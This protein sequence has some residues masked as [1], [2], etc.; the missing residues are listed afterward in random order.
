VRLISVWLTGLGLLD[1]EKVS[2]LSLLPQEGLAGRLT[3]LLFFRQT[4]PTPRVRS[5]F[6][7]SSSHGHSEGSQSAASQSSQSFHSLQPTVLA[8][9]HD[10]PR[11]SGMAQSA[12]RKTNGKTNGTFS[13][14]SRALV[15]TPRGEESRDARK[16]AYRRRSEQA[17]SRSTLREPDARVSFLPHCGGLY[18]DAGCTAAR[19]RHRGGRR[20]GVN[21]TRVVEHQRDDQ[22][23]RENRRGKHQ[24]SRSLQAL[25]R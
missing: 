19:Q 11:P 21:V 18:V 24:Q 15:P 25:P 9:S 3:P 16:G 2:S 4:P 17:L 14:S 1:G 10:T 7:T 22:R 13:K 23:V 5:P 12:R 20:S 8:S 6:R